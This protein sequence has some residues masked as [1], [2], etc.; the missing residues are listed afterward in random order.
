MTIEL[1]LQ[2]VD[3]SAVAISRPTNYLRNAFHISWGLVGATLTLLLSPGVLVGV[4]LAF[5]AAS[6]TMELVRR[7]SPAFNQRIMRVFRHVSRPHEV[8][9]VNSSTWYASALLLLT[10]SFEPTI[11]LTGVLVLAFADPAAAIIGRRFG[12]VPLING[13]TVEGTLTFAFVGALVS[14]TVLSLAGGGLLPSYAFGVRL[15][16]ALAAG[17]LGA[18]AELVSD[19]VDDNFSIPLSSALA[20]WAVLLLMA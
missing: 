15:T 1:P 14:F 6:W 17:S 3:S 8:E 7:R 4:A 11:I 5:A 9:Q 10:L 20:A 16:I 13:R 18:I 12:R 19:R 2:H